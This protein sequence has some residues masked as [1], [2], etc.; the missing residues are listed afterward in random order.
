MDCIISTSNDLNLL[1]ARIGVAHLIFVV[2][3]VG[4][5]WFYPVNLA[6]ARFPQNSAAKFRQRENSPRSNRETC[7]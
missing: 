5:N 6:A 4:F 2:R 3:F 1:T 7:Y